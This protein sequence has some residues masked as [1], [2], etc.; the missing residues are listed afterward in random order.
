[1]LLSSG[2]IRDVNPISVRRYSVGEE[3]GFDVSDLRDD[4]EATLRSGRL[5]SEWGRDWAVTRSKL[6]R[7]DELADLSLA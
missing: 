6:V 7:L 1:M 3:I 4:V 5:P 2:G